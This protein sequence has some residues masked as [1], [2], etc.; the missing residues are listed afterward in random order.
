MVLSADSAASA[1]EQ[2][3]SLPFMKEGIMHAELVTLND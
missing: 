2:V 1:N 3:S